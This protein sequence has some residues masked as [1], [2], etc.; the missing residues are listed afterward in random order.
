MLHLVF[1]KK[2]RR[3]ETLQ[4]FDLTNFKLINKEMYP[5]ICIQPENIYIH[6]FKH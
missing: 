5:L 1:V 4:Y 2:H 6:A 3:I